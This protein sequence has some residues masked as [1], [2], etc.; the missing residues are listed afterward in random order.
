M[1]F[2]KGFFAFI[3]SFSV[4]RQNRPFLQAPAYFLLTYITKYVNIK[5]LCFGGLAMSVAN[6]CIIIAI[7]VYL[8]AMVIVG[9]V[10]SKRIIVLMTSISEAGSLGRL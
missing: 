9:I 4:F 6:I 1:P 8:A 5:I 10:C 2:G 7:V 3:V